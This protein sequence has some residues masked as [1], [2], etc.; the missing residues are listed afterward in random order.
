M[1]GWIPLALLSVA[2]VISIRNLV[3]GVRAKYGLARALAQDTPT[4]TRL[5]EAL[6]RD[7]IQTA[8]AVL[9]DQVL[10]LPGP[11]RVQAVSALDQRS[12]RGR[13]SYMAD[14]VAHDA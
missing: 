7:D 4:R 10:A 13:A 11:V 9:E 14:L 8:R 2:A 12:Q 6:S 1:L 3:N 5:R